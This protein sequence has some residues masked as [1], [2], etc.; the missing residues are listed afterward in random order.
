[1]KILLCEDDGNIATIAKLTLEQLGGHDVTWVQDGESA[2]K[3]GI[4]NKYDVI[5]LDDM[6]PKMSGVDVCKS[7]VQSGQCQ[8]PVIFMSANPQDKRVVEFAPVTVGYI[9]K[10]FDPV[11]LNQQ[12][13]EMLKNK[14]AA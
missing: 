12:I 14:R 4:E 8:S 3:H 1:M 9:P 7:F 6:M 10:P 13:T 5:L 11:T 2:F